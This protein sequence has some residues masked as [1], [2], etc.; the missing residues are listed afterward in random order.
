MLSLPPALPPSNRAVLIFQHTQKN[1]SH[2]LAPLNHALAKLLQP[3]SLHADEAGR[4]SR[5]EITDLI[6]AAL[7]H[8]VQLL[9][10]GPAADDAECAFV[11]TTAH[12]PVDGNLRGRDAVEEEFGFGREVEAVVEDFSVGD[13][14]EGVLWR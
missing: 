1:S 3:D 7:A 5:A 10:V 8:V 6:H 12:G 9:G 4:I 13:C 14:D 2:L 11:D